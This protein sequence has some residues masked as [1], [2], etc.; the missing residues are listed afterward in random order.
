M[1]DKQPVRVLARVS[2]VMVFVG[3]GVG[4]ASLLTWEW[5]EASVTSSSAIGSTE[6]VVIEGYT[7]LAFLII[8]SITAPVVSGILGIFEGLRMD[9]RLTTVYVA[10]GCFVG[11]ALLVF[12]AGV[13]IGQTGTGG[14]SPVGP[15]ELVSLAGL[16]GLVSVLSG[17]LTSVFGSR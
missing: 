5:I 10:V 1:F 11:A 3:I 13:F 2:L 12:V 17:S 9:Q 16:S 4:L 8:S 14:E 6:K 15:A 7:P